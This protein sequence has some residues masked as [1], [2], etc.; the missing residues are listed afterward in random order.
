MAPVEK[1]GS[2]AY[3][4][5]AVRVPLSFSAVDA[6][7]R[8]F[9]ESVDWYWMPKTDHIRVAFRNEADAVLFETRINQG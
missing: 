1:I 8:V 5:Y 9:S 4:F 2:D 7:K 6:I 3:P